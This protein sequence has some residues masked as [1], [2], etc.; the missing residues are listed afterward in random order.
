MS[1]TQSVL[2]QFE[3]LLF[4]VTLELVFWRPSLVFPWREEVLEP[5]PDHIVAHYSDR[6]EN[7]CVKSSFGCSP[8]S[9]KSDCA[10]NCWVV[11]GLIFLID[12]KMIDVN[13]L[14]K[15]WTILWSFTCVAHEVKPFPMATVLSGWRKP[16]KLGS[17]RI[18]QI[19]A[20][21][22]ADDASLAIMWQVKS[23]CTTY[24]CAQLTAHVGSLS[25]AHCA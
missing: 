5:E 1:R 16:R 19:S 3:W 11:G 9:R 6:A 13:A 10:H 24:V 22:N 14:W 17:H 20:A 2:V 18:F 23:T 7:T 12:Q 8:N 4:I 21:P 25:N 15:R